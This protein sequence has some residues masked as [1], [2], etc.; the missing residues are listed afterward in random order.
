MLVVDPMHNL[1]LGTAKHYFKSIWIETVI[2]ND[3]DF[4]MI[5]QHVDSTTVPAGVGRILS[6]IS[7][8]F[9]SFTA[10]QWKNWV[11][12]FSLI[13]LLD[14]LHDDGLECWCHFVLACR[15]LLIFYLRML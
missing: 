3:N 1:F 14:N 15:I 6:K 10:D 11:S 2:L 9:S 4:E 12:Y 5:Q 13:S 7:S 8:G